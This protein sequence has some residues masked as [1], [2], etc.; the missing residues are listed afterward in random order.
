MEAPENFTYNDKGERIKAVGAPNSITRLYIEH[1]AL[2]ERLK[3]LGKVEAQKMVDVMPYHFIDRITQEWR[4]NIMK[5]AFPDFLTALNL[6]IQ[7]SK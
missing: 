4:K 5:A 6:H 7:F 1:P 2:I 3:K